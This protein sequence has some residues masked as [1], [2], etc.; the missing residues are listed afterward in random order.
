MTSK[1]FNRRQTRWSEFLSHIK[2]KI[3]YCPGKQGQKPDALR[4]MP[5]DMPPKGGAEKNEQIM[6]KT[7]NLD[8][9]VRRTMIVAF[10]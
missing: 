9:E 3:V 4:R 7:E 5:G 8:K 1:L 2:F 10:A 6:L